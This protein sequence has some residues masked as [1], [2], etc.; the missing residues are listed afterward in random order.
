[1]E[2]WPRKSV[3]EHLRGN[4][5]AS[6]AKQWCKVEVFPPWLQPVSGSMTQPV[7][8]PFPHR[9]QAVLGASRTGCLKQF[10]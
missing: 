2:K 5:V 6:T 4:E 9:Q 1:M 8:S 10:T 3:L 7:V